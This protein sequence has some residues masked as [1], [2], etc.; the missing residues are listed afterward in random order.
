MMKTVVVDN[1]D[2][3]FIPD[4]DIYLELNAKEN[5]ATRLPSVA[6]NSIL[7]PAVAMAT[8]CLSINK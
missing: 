1:D 3:K 6:R 8:A 7:V 5:N 4:A 2:D